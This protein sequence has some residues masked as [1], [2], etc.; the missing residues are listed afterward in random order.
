MVL[1]HTDETGYGK[2]LIKGER[3]SDLHLSHQCKADRVH[4]AE[5]LISVPA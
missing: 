3:L 1:W 2:M 4:I 5:I